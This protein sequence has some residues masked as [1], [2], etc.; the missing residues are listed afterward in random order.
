M[1]ILRQPI[2]NQHI[3]KEKNKEIVLSAI[4][5]LAP[6]SRAEIAQRSGL[7]KATVSSLVNEL[8]DEELIFE[9]GPGESNGGRRPV[10]LLFNESA[11]YSIGVDIGVNYIF[12]IVTD[13]VGNVIYEHH[14]S[15]NHLPF[16]VLISHVKETIRALI[17][18]TPASRY[19]VVGIGVGVP[20]I[21]DR[22]GKVLLAPNLNWKDIDLLGILREE[23]PYPIL[24]ENEANAGAYGE[25]RFGAGQNNDHIVYVSVGIGI[26]V[27]LIM[28]GGLYQ[29]INGYSGESG[30]M[31]IVANG[32]K[33]T[34]GNKGCWEAYASE[35]ALLKE[36][37]Q[38]EHLSGLNLEELIQMADANDP[39][40]IKLFHKIGSNIG[41]GVTNLI[42]TLNPQQIII[43]NRLAKA[44]HLIE[45]AIKESV[46]C[47]T[48]PFH[49][50]DLQINFSNLSTYSTAIGASAFIIEDFL[51]ISNQQQVAV[52][53]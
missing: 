52:E 49:L 2:W 14:T 42:K 35:Y 41:I 19:G 53:Q 51:K 30:H 8:I 5:K 43:G 21:T 11:G 26:G 38:F 20:G 25:K 45:E 16:E 12:G 27:G 15:I 34:C 24:I 22:N 47:Q 50:A 44:Q 33:C 18:H 29:G 3:V 9:S 10:M 7:N 31:T 46:S 4:T 13:L 1:G 37:K 6:L 28:Q 36:A 32:E 23:F 48:M 40:S 39:V 17:Q